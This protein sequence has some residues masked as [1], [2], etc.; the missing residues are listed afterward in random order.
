MKKLLLVCALV[1]GVSAVSLAQGG[2]QR[3][4]P[5]EQVEQLKEKIAG[6]TDDQTAKL[7]VIYT[8]AAK[9]RDSLMTAARDAGGDRASMMATFMKLNATNDAKIKTVLT[10]DQATA[11]QKIADER[12]AAMKARMA[13]N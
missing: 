12:A 11:Y 4:T 9:K 6:I 3:R 13:G 5:K 7:T 1:I 8:D 10:A 2:G